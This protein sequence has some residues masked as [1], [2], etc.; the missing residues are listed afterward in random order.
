MAYLAD[1]NGGFRV[2]LAPSTDDRKVTTET[3]VR[4]DHVRMR[5]P[6]QDRPALEVG[7]LTIRKG[8]RV[9]LIG[10]S[11]GGKTTLLRLINGTLAPTAGRID[12]L[13]ESVE[14]GAAR[15]REQRRRTGMI[16]QGFALVE[17]ATVMQNVLAGRLGYAHPWLS[18]FGRFADEDR[19]LA[20]EA[21][22]EVD[23]LDK[24]HERVDGL[25]GGQRQRVAIARVLAQAPE[26]ILADEPVSQLDPALTLE[27]ID[28]LT[29]ASERREATLV[30]AVH[31][32][33]LAIAHM[34]RIIAVKDAAIVF[35]GPPSALSG[36]VRS[37]I[38]DRDTQRCPA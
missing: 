30:M 3:V 28:L 19:R 27:I 7:D 25:S 23:L 17:R 11:G 10:P 6:G 9:A 4:L 21:I 16:F 32:P 33:D 14:P 20:M 13:G 26:L 29:K 12:V 35:D 24:V 2:D 37:R 34:E 8:E 15:P 31:Q 22:M 36:E 5:Y 18:L 38:Y 1:R